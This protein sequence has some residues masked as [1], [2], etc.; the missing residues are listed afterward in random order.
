[1]YLQNRDSIQNEVKRL[2]DL[3]S[4][5]EQLSIENEAADDLIGLMLSDSCI[6]V[7]TQVLKL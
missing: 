4:K 5:I 1:M 3:S 7:Y 6:W 2:Q